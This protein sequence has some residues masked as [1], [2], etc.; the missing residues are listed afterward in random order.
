MGQSHL[1]PHCR[2]LLLLLR[3]C[4]WFQ[5]KRKRE[6]KQKQKRRCLH[7]RRQGAP[8]NGVGLAKVARLAVGW[9]CLLEG[10]T[11]SAVEKRKKT[12]HGDMI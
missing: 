11:R 3:C 8:R 12:T 9:G 10:H 7:Q 4:C 5:R 2:Y 6:R 1:T